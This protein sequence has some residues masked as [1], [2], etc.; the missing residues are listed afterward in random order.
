MQYLLVF[1]EGIITFIS[2]CLLPMLPLYVSYFAGGQSQGRKKTAINALGFIF[3]FTLVFMLLG[4]F[5]GT[6][7]HLLKSHTMIVNLITGGLVV[8]F[9]LNYLGWLPIS[10]FQRHNTHQANVE[11]LHF[12]SSM[13][14]GFIFSIGWTPCVGA[15]LGTALALAS[16][17]G[18]ALEGV[19]ML[20]IYSLGLGIPFMISALLIDSFKT[21]FDWIKTHYDLINRI[22]GGLL[23]VLGLLIMTGTMGYLLSFLSF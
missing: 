18:S 2:P 7:G 8:G 1:L 9:G 20:L 16:Q 4:L 13:L 22:S 17:K 19:F 21:T 6:I 10:L 14:F 5:A 23:I 15:F 11:N 3:G 12:F